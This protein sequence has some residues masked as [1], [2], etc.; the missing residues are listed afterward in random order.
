[1]GV[2]VHV[3][4]AQPVG[5]P[6]SEA[7]TSPVTNLAREPVTD[8]KYRMSTSFWYDEDDEALS[9]RLDRLFQNEFFRN[10]VL[11][12]RSDRIP[13]TQ[14]NLR[15]VL[16][17]DAYRTSDFRFVVPRG[18]KTVRG[19]V[20]LTRNSFWMPSKFTSFCELTFSLS[21]GFEGGPFGDALEVRDVLLAFVGVGPSPMG[22]VGGED[23]P[24]EQS[25]ARFEAF[26]R[27]DSLAV[28]ASI[29]WVTVLHEDV[30][31]RMGV[32]LFRAAHEAGVLAGRKDNYLWII[33]CERPFSFAKGVGTHEFR[34]IHEAVRL[35]VIHQRFRRA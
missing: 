7:G 34:R 26:R 11:R 10:A 19:S 23:V 20:H 32:D 21:D 9:A 31:A 30:V 27:T 6:L 33:L 8:M 4:A 18:R 12:P 13:P 24:P 5:K 29:E 28:P 3:V 22:F 15:R 16:V 35:D 14:E 2:V 17:P 1:M 25:R